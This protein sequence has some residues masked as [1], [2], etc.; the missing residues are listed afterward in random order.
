VAT[1]LALGGA[2]ILL[3]PSAVPIGYEY[4]L[5]LRTRARART[6]RCSRSP[7]T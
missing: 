5:A 4:L 7:A 2:Q 1:I 3:I 6:T